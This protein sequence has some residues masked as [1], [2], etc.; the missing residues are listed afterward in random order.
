MGQSLSPPIREE[1]VASR[2]SGP[3]P[4]LGRSSL[5]LPPCGGGPGW[6]G[7]IV[8]ANR[9]K[10]PA[11]A[12]DGLR[13]GF[14]KGAYSQKKMAQSRADPPSTCSTGPVAASRSRSE[15]AEIHASAQPGA[16]A[17]ESSVKATTSAEACSRPR[18]RSRG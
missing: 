12:G 8:R 7:E 9:F 15:K 6:G 16:K 4:L 11:Y 17:H 13:I 5:S 2:P 14:R 3:R 10:A 18:R 1:S